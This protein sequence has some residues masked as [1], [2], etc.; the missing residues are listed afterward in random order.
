MIIT[1]FPF[2]VLR[3]ILGVPF[4][5]FF[6]GYTLIAALF[7][8]RGSIGSVERMT[9][10][11][12]FSFV[13]VSLIGVILNYTPWGIRLYPILISLTIFIVTTSAVAWHRQRKLHEV[14]KFTL[15]FNL[16]LP[17]WRGQGFLDKT[18]SIILVAAILGT[19]GT[20]GYFVVSPKVGERFTEFYLEGLED[21]AMDYPR[22]LNIG[23]M[24]K[25]IVG[26]TNH[27]KVEA[28]YRLE[29]RIDGVKNSEVEQFVLGDEQ[30]WE[31][32][33]SF[34]PDSVGDNQKVEF[35]LYKNKGGEPYRRLHI[36]VNVKE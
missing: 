24:G 20:L 22:E 19:I 32:T 18:L 13:V 17:L 10:S 16:G 21:K 34:T 6:P 31:E 26:V 28:S 15:S 25:V 27:E 14:E 12:G 8:R 36:W 11:F 29:V 23:G 30:K 9:L 33:V 5:V 35:L 2:E 7:P 4:L 1:L 3:I